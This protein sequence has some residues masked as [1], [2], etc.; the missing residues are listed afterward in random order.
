MKRLN[1]N[2]LSGN[3]K[4]E[5]EEY[6]NLYS[7]YHNLITQY[8]ANK[9]G[10]SLIDRT[11]ENS[12]LNYVSIKEEDMDIYQYLS[13]D[14]MNYFYLRNDIHLE[15]LDDNEIA[16]LKNLSNNEQVELNEEI[17]LYIESTMSKALSSLID[18]PNVL[19]TYGP[20]AMEYKVPSNSLVIGFRYD[21]FNLD[22]MTEEEWDSNHDEKMMDL[23]DMFELLYDNLRKFKIMPVEIIQYSDTSVEKKTS[24]SNLTL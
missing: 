22:G 19:A 8:M 20:N 23:S 2:D 7:T 12:S 5:K 10:L 17:I 14:I 1:I 9:M 24:S 18:E 11:I 3:D 13:S 16:F 4:F 21:E 6:V 15:R